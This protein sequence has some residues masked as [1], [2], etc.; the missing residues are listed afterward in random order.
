M[1]S[2]NNNTTAPNNSQVLRAV[3][4][5]AKEYLPFGNVIESAPSSSIS[6]NQGTAQRTNGLAQLENLRGELPEFIREYP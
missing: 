5:T 1:M 6:A 4:L 3:P 2:D